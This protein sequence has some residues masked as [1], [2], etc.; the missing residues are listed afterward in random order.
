VSRR[1]LAHPTSSFRLPSAARRT[2][3]HP[4]WLPSPLAGQRRPVSIRIL[5][6][7]HNAHV[8]R[9]HWSGHIHRLRWMER[10]EAGPYRTRCTRPALSSGLFGSR[11][12]RAGSPGFALTGSHATPAAAPDRQFV[13]GAVPTVYELAGY[14]LPLPRTKLPANCR[15]VAGSAPVAIQQPML[16]STAV[17]SWVRLRT[18]KWVV[19]HVSAPRMPTFA[20]TNSR[21]R[22]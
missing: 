8:I 12:Q 1:W 2:P 6:S 9:L 17:A 19:S 22:Y 21:F 11:Q 18:G 7:I 15:Q 13:D 20:I 16:G 14:H 3:F 4:P 5:S 10:G